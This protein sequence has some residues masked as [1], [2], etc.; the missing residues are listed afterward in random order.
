MSARDNILARIRSARGAAAA[1][2]QSDLAAIDG[3]INQHPVGTRPAMHWEQ[4]PRFREQCVRMSSTVDEVASMRDVPAAVARFLTEQGLPMRAVA[5]PKIAHLDWTGTGVTVE[6][7]PARGDDLV[8]ITGVHLAL[9]ETGTVMLLS[10]VDTPAATSL[11]PETHIAVVP[12]GRI[13]LAMEEAWARTREELGELPRAVNFVSGPSRTAD[14]EG[15][16]QIGA[17]GPFRVH[18]I[19]AMS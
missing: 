9:A 2:A 6:D 17:H 10:G 11:L 18:V 8:G 19:V 3:R 7:R 16:L 5:W 13:V 4:V 12:A 15:Q 14:I 1:S